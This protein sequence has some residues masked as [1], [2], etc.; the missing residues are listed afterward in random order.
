MQIPRCILTDSLKEVELHDFADASKDAYGA[1]IYLRSVTILNHVKVSLLWSKSK[2]APFKVVTILRL[3]LCAA[4]PV[5]KLASKTVSSLI[6][7]KICIYS[8]PTI[9]LVWINTS[10]YLHKVFLSNRIS[11]IQE[12]TKE[13]F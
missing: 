11:R 2:V 6:I 1:V 13:F 12:R 4:E 10:S 5:A 3:E 8:N 9:V 7:Y